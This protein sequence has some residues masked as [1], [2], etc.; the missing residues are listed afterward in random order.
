MLKEI[1]LLA[2]V[3]VAFA[4]IDVHLNEG[5]GGDCLFA[6]NL[7]RKLH[8][9][10]ALT[11][12]PKLSQLA[13]SRAA[14]LAELE[15]LNV[16]QNKMHGQALGET[17][18]SVGGFTNYNGISATQLWYSVVSKFDEEGELSSDGASF[19][20]MVWKSTKLAG[21]GIAKSKSGKFYFVAEYFPSGN[22]RHQYESN[23]FQLTDDELVKPLDCSEVAAIVGHKKGHSTMVPVTTSV[24]V[25]IQKPVIEVADVEVVKSK[26]PTHSKVVDEAAV[27]VETPVKTKV[28]GHSKVVD[29][30]LIDVETPVRKVTPKTVV[31][32]KEEPVVSVTKHTTTTKVVPIDVEDEEE[33]VVETPRKKT[34]VSPVT[35]AEPVEVVTKKPKNDQVITL[36]TP[37]DYEEDA[38]EVKTTTKV[39]KKVAK[40]ETTTLVS[41]DTIVDEEAVSTT[42]VVPTTK[43]TTEAVVDD[44][45]EVVDEP[46]TVTKEVK[47]TTEVSKIEDALVDS[48]ETLVPVVT[49]PAK[50]IVET[51]SKVAKSVSVDEDLTETVAEPVVVK[52]TEKSKR[53]KIVNKKSSSHE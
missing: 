16:K 11:L 9:V 18:G 38:V 28:P 3:S 15:E 33:V 10:P 35:V 21:F 42:T 5:F 1:L 2:L 48:E 12:S 41:D 45:V 30:T 32:D 51:T 36:A 27:D 29:E 14:E 7:Y 46:T 53:N 47:T 19:T 25:H 8:G 24:P 49:K 50:I 34:T 4:E 17:V 22:I 26:V 44:S 20:Q 6:H 52:K 40:V 43:R 23:V 37:L 31:V 13:M 39:A